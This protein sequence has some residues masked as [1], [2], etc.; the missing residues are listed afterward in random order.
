MEKIT[1]RVCGSRN[2]T[3]LFDLGNTPLANS[4]RTSEQLKFVEPYY[5]L[6]INFC[7]DCSFVQLSEVVSPE[8][9]FKDYLYTSSTSPTFVKHFEDLAGEACS[10]FNLQKG[11]LVVD[12]GSNDGI[13]LRPFDNLGMRVL[14]FDPAFKIAEEAT[15]KGILT[16]PA[17]FS[18]GYAEGVKK[19]FGCGAKIV[20]ATSVFPHIDNLAQVI[21]GIKELLEDDGVFI[22][23]CYYLKELIAI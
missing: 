17:Y 8:I 18:K 10:R 22:I 2:L 21:E 14:G 19:I 13:M 11:D 1:C 6:R 5:P 7:D 15:S 12:I 23:E 20:T 4:F 3:Q 9:L 16:I